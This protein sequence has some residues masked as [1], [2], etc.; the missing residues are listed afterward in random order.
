MSD[1]PP[2]SAAPPEVLAALGATCAALWT[3]IIVAGS[4][5]R[6]ARA[7]STVALAA[8]SVAFL[9]LQQSEGG[10]V[11]SC[12]GF[13]FLDVDFDKCRAIGAAIARAGQAERGWLAL[14]VSKARAEN[15]FAL[16]MGIGALYSLLF[17]AKGT[18]EVAVVHLMHA[19]WAISVCAV[20]AVQA[21]PSLKAHPVSNFDR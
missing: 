4:L 15:C 14:A 13:S 5:P 6:L 8:S 10:L 21:D 9:G 12:H 19:A 1:P 18:R 3:A 7:V 17:L 11:D 16:G 2:A 20:G